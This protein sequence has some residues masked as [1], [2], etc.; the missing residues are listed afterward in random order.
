MSAESAP[1]KLESRREIRE[2]Q[3]LAATMR[4]VRTHGTTIT[5]AQ[6][7][8]AAKCSKET[9]YG[10]F[11]DRDGIML[12]LVREQARAMGIFL[13]HSF[14][15]VE[16]K[17]EDRL[18]AAAALLLD[19]M[20]GDAVI[21]VNRI[22][23]AQA[24]KTAS[25][26]GQ[27]VLENWHEQVE[28]PFYRLFQEGTKAGRLVVHSDDEAFQALL[29]LLVGDRQRRI[30]LGANERPNPTDMLA[31]ADKAVQRWLILYRV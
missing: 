9:L 3:I 16:G 21:V 8:G 26:L 30:L 28:R 24:C 5:T 6:I 7:A 15:E 12:A 25:Q 31:I 18:R 19:I 2:R 17:L 27:A 11:E 14:A 23:M 4:L 22:A 1:S 20:T 10:W 13:E 29:G